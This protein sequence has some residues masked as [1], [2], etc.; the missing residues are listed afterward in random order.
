[1]NEHTIVHA[2]SSMDIEIKTLNEEWEYAVIHYRII[3]A[4][5]PFKEMEHQHF[6][7]KTLLV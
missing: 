4:P 5:Y 6:M 3:D 2:G 1:M 7:M